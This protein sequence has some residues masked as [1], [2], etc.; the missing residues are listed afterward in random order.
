MRLLWEGNW[1]DGSVNYHNM[2]RGEECQL[3]WH[4]G[5]NSQLLAWEI[6]FGAEN[7]PDLY[8][9]HSATCSHTIQPQPVTWKEWPAYASSVLLLWLTFVSFQLSSTGSNWRMSASNRPVFTL[10]SFWRTEMKLIQLILHISWVHLQEH[11]QWWHALNVHA[12]NGSDCE[13]EKFKFWY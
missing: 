2:V 8:V 10:F 1:T 12:T 7:G 4:F 11:T 6:T 13:C 9:F 3:G 5:S